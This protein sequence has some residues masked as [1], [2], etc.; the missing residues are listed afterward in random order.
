MG[1]FPCFDDLFIDEGASSSSSPRNLS[2]FSIKLRPQELFALIRFS[3]FIRIA[4]RYIS[5]SCSGSP[6][7]AV[8]SS[9][10]SAS[11]LPDSLRKRAEER[12]L[13]LCCFPAPDARLFAPLFSDFTPPPMASSKVSSSSSL[14]SSDSS[15]IVRG[16]RY[17][18]SS[19]SSSSS[20]SYANSMPPFSTPKSST[21]C[22]MSIPLFWSSVASTEDGSNRRTTIF[23]ELHLVSLESHFSCTT[24]DIRTQRADSPFNVVS[25]Q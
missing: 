19:P 21:S 10:P 9:S 7:F 17:S 13:R 22:S 1:P 15:A 8:L 23:A 18:S 12:L 24:A 5:P 16:A 4:C 3:A 2:I 25:T 6:V 14:S 11:N 20:S